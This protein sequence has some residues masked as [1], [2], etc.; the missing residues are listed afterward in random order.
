MDEQ[1][2]FTYGGQ[3]V[4]EG[5]MIRGRTH[6]ALA[7]RRPDGSIHRHQERLGSW[8][9]GRLRRVPLLRGVLVLAESLTLGIKTLQRSANLAASNEGDGQDEIPKWAMAGTLAFSLILGISIF[10]LLPVLAVRLA[11]P[12]IASD[13]VSNILEGVLR[14]AI[15]VGYIWAIGRSRDIQRVFAYHGAEHMAVHTYEA[16]LPL[17]VANVRKFGTPHPRCGTAFLLTVML[18]SI[19]VFAFLQRPPLEWR[20]ISRIALVPVIAGISY[21]IIRF[22][23]THQSAWLGR[24][25]AKPGLLLQRLTTRQPDD[26]QIEVAITAMETAIAADQE[27]E[28]APVEP[29]QRG[30]PDVVRTSE[31]AGSVAPG[32][33]EAGAT[34][35]G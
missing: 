8:A 11:D 19:I 13:L 22:S 7:V 1:R 5:V 20:I 14:L 24:Q 17:E 35:P 3:A 12:F 18:V 29:G 6:F 23:G 30:D 4:I 33:G 25:L 28:V 34:T 21:E 9:T 16:G 27:R 32:E 10:F 31:E 15:L 26:R 2:R